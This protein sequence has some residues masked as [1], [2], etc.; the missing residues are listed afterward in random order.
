MK[1]TRCPAI[2]VSK[3]TRLR[4]PVSHPAATASEPCGATSAKA[5]LKKIMNGVDKRAP[6]RTEKLLSFLLSLEQQRKKATAA[7]ECTSES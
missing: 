7:A 1:P 3:A 5:L 2:K 4:D 6:R